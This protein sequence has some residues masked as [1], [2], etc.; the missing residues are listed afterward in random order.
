MATVL[1]VFDDALFS[2]LATLDRAVKYNQT[3]I[4]RMNNVDSELSWESKYKLQEER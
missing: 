3:K 2:M 4:F 1:K